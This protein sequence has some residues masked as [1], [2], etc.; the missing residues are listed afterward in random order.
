MST[1]KLIITAS[2]LVV[3]LPL[4]AQDANSLLY[5]VSGNDLEQP[6]YLFGTIHLIRK[7][8]K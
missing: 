8:R 4:R 1:L 6:S 2:V 3:S 7:R 5:E